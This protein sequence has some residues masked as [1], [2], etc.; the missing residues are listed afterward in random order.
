[1]RRLEDPAAKPSMRLSKGVH[2]VVDGGDD[3][4]AALTISHDKVRVSFAVP[5]EGKLLLGTTDTEHDGE[6]EDA[7]V[8]DDDVQQ[9]LTEAAVAVDGLGTPRATFY[10]LRVLPGGEGE[11]AN[12]RRETVYST[13]PTGMV[14]V[15]GGKL[16]TYRRIALDALQHL[17]VRGLSKTPRP[18]PGATGL[19]RIDWPVELDARTR[20]HLLHLYGSLAPEMLAP[21]VDDASLLE[22]LV[23]GRPDLRAQDLY[24]R[25]HEWAQTDEDVL[26]RR[27]TG[28]LAGNVE[29]QGGTPVPSRSA[30]GH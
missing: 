18:L 1:L 10:G 17:G 30:A 28:W 4:D 27:T 15:A 9:V 3:W 16:T 24:A 13:G 21:A 23:E 26:R 22:P 7:R 14:S 29:H 2:V 5:W 12:A 11:T 6:P 25:T 8:T 20:T 19:E